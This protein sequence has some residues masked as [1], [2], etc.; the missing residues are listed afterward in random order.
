LFLFCLCVLFLLFLLFF[1]LFCHG[2]SY[3]H[4][5]N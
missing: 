3:E 2:D 4:T 5:P 1:I